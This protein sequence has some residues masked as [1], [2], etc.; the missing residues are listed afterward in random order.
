MSFPRA[1][2]WFVALALV[3]LGATTAA[4][5]TVDVSGTADIFLAGQTTVPTD[6]AYNPGTGGLGAGSLP[7]S[8]SVFGGEVLNLTAT[9]TVSCCLGGSP[10]NG[11]DGGGL[12]GG[13]S[14]QGY[15]N[16][17]YLYTSGTQMAL[18]GVFGGSSL[19]TPWTI[20]QV[21]SSDL[22]LVVPTGA[23]QLYFGFAD[24]YGFNSSNEGGTGP[25]NLPGW[26]N[27]NTGSISVSYTPLPATWTLMLVGLAG[28]GFVAYRRQKQST[29][30]AAA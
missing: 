8:I 16:V 1:R 13:T 17:N 30:I 12:G 29:A 26:Y 10:T 18:L 14:I 5:G 6:W 9:G 24:A 22:G 4:A 25:N 19:T 11:P 28:L 3:G 15:G 20:F 21:G 27:D 7:P 23:T 2:N